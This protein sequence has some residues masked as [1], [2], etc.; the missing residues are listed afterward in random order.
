M[1]TPN[2]CALRAATVLTRVAVRDPRVRNHTSAF[3]NQRPHLGAPPAS[4]RLSSAIL[5]G[6]FRIPDGCNSAVSARLRPIDFDG[7]MH[8]HRAPWSAAACSAA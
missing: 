5:G 3:P 2:V 4:S 6:V 7:C 8:R 1:R